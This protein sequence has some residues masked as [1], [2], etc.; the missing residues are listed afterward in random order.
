[1]G[2]SDEA[3]LAAQVRREWGVGETQSIDI[4][5][6]L[7]TWERISVVRTPFGR[8]SKVSGL[9][10]RKNRSVIIVL[11]SNRTL[12]HQRFIAAHEL[13]HVKFGE[14]MT[15][16]VCSAAQFPERQPD[17]LSADRFAAHL[18]VPRSGV[19]AILAMHGSETAPSWPTI[20]KLEQYF[21]VSHRAMLWR[22]L[23]LGYFRNREQME[24]YGSNVIRQARLLGYDTRLYESDL[25]HEV[26]SDVPEK[27]RVA[28]ADGLISRGWADELLDAMGVVDQDT[29]GGD[30]D[31]LD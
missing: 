24:E 12:G 16:R 1:M 20:L 13:Y 7:W 17:E 3:K 30:D 31:Q 29:G 2:V 14:G 18:L 25:T 10:A 4:L 11:N 15:G 8:S 26:L 23:D 28:L 21:K 5:R 6:I 19:E 22:L 27:I 9:F